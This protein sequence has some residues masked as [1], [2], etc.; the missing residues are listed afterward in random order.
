MKKLLLLLVPFTFLQAQQGLR[1]PTYVAQLQKVAAGGG[2]APTPS[3]LRWKLNDG[4]GTAITAD[5]GPNGTTDG[6]WGS[7]YATFNGTSQEASTDSTITTGVTGVTTSM[8]ISRAS[9]NAGGANSVMF[10][11]GPYGNNGSVQIREQSDVIYFVIYDSGGVREESITIGA[12]FPTSQLF[13]IAAA[14]DNSTVSGQITVWT[15]GVE[16]TGMSVSAGK[17]GSGNIYAGTVFI[18]AESAAGGWVAADYDDVAIHS[19]LLNDS[20]VAAIYAA[21]PQ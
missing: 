13:H 14:F 20:Q 10:T 16:M 11:I 2:G 4:S 21:G 12:K 7:G 17:G 9:W 6:G 15:N 19:G 8:W 5:V 3:I 1:S 18:G